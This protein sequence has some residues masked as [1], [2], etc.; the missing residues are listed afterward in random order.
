MSREGVEAVLLDMGGVLIPEVRGFEAAAENEALRAELA[1]RGVADPRA[2]LLE[3]GQRLR[4]AYRDLEAQRSQP[5]PERVLA[6]LPAEV[7]EQVLQAF[8]REETLPAFPEARE[9]VARLART[10]RLGIVSNT[11]VPGDHHARALERA[12]IL[13]FIS[14][15]AWS[16]NFGSRKPATSIIEHVLSKLGIPA[17]RAVFVGDKI[18]TDIVGARSAGLRSVWLRRPDSRDTGEATPDWVIDDLRDLPALLEPL[19]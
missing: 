9:V 19:R 13:E 8:A 11:I 18:R 1:Q 5:D 6:T 7:R 2:T 14:A 12:G 15:A 17:R 10:F 4:Q 16:A 3:A